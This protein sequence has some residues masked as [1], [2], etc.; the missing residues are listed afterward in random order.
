MIISMLVETGRYILTMNR[1]TAA[2]RIR[3]VTM[4][5]AMSPKVF[6][7]L[8]VAVVVAVPACLQAEV[9]TPIIRPS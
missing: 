1:T 5:T 7:M 2:A 9:A 3:P 4:A 8:Q 6:I